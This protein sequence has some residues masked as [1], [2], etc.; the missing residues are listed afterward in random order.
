ME[1]VRPGS[2]KERRRALI[3]MLLF[4][5]LCYVLIHDLLGGTLFAHC[6]WDSYTLQSLAWLEGRMDLD[7]DYSYLELAIYNGKYYVSFP[8]VPSVVMLPFAVVFGEQ[9]PNNLIIMLVTML[10]AAAAFSIASYSG[11]NAKNSAL[12]ALSITFGSNVMWMSTSGGVWFMAQTLAMLFLLLATISAYKNKAVLAYALIALAVG[13]RPF[14]AVAFLPAFIWFYGKN[15]EAGMGRAKA[16]LS[17]WKALIP[18]II[19]AAVMMWY[20]YAR[21]DNP[22]EFGHN[23]LP[24]YVE[25]E[26]G[27]FNLCYIFDNIARI[28]RPV[29]LKEGLR[30]DYPYFDGFMFFIANPFFLLLFAANLR[31]II[32]RSF[33]S[34]RL[35]L[36]LAMLIMLICLCMHKTFGGWQFG[37]RYT[38]DMLPPALIYVCLSDKKE[39]KFWEKAAAVFG[40]AFNIYGALAMTFLY[41]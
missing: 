32:K 10:C 5:L 33:S 40:M 18:V 3:A 39:L 35:G 37:A 41:S 29:K 17:Q 31:N 11:F 26:N 20:N 2:T 12:L 38:C 30:L 14:S 13:C 27:Q 7:R 19:I 24:E 25:S 8:P 34:V 36:A 22:L 6:P 23:Y 28:L 15:R 4:M 9:T 21:F 16:A 1:N